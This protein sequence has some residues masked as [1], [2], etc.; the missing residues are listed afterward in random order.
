VSAG[1]AAIDAELVLEANNIYVADIEEVGGSDI[2]RQVLFFNFEANYIGIFVATR[3][4]VYRNREA[5]T[6]RVGTSNRRK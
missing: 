2:G 3:K 5:L 4:I 1:R 6:M